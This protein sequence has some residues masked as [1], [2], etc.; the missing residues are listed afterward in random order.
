MEKEK[1]IMEKIIEIEIEEKKM[2][3]YLT[4]PNNGSQP[5][6][7]IILFQEAF[8]VNSHIQDIARRFA[9]AGYAVIAPEIYHRTAVAGFTCGYTEFNLALPHFSAITSETIIT[10]ANASFHYLKSELGITDISSVGFCLGGRA[11]FIANS[12]L[13]LTA[14][15][16]FYGGRIAPNH[17]DLAQKQKGPLLLIWAGFDDHISKD[18]CRNIADELEKSKHT[19][20]EVKFSWAQHGFFCNERASYNKQAA[21]QA[22]ALTL[23]FLNF[24]SAETTPL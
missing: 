9:N 2:R 22:W 4:T 20:T 13:P 24:S 18:D 16:A 1:I 21:N 8:G 19:F 14:A 10:D 6:R 15:I 11:S 23:E 3:A 5:T 17:L 7:G 12:Q